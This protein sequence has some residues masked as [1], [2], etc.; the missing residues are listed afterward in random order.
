[1]VAPYWGI[2]ILCREQNDRKWSLIRQE[3]NNMRLCKD[4]SY[5]NLGIACG[6]ILDSFVLTLNLG[7]WSLEVPLKDGKL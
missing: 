6:W 7:F 5:F 1:M 3:K 2:T 4:F